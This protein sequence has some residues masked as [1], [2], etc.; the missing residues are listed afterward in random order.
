[1]PPIRLTIAGQRW[2]LKLVRSIT[3]DGVACD[4]LC[5][6]EKREIRVRRDLEGQELIDTVTHEVMH[7]AGWNLHETFVAQTATDIAAALYHPDLREKT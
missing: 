7:A 6:Y 3:H 4:G 5:N 1:M 2:T